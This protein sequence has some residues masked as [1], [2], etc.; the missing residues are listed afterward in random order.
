MNYKSMVKVWLISVVLIITSCAS[1]QSSWMTLEYSNKPFKN[2]ILESSN[3]YFPP[4]VKLTDG[5]YIWIEPVTKYQLSGAQS[6]GLGHDLL[7]VYLW[8]ENS[9]E[10]DL[11]SSSVKGRDG[12]SKSL[13]YVATLNE[14]LPIERFHNK[15]KLSASNPGSIRVLAGLTKKTA[16]PAKQPKG[17]DLKQANHFQLGFEPRIECSDEPFTISMRFIDYKGKE[18]ELPLYFYPVIYTGSR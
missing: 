15:A 8:S 18:F 6:C 13:K 17:R 7:N 10:L 12:V 3:Y 1:A 2:M 4:S 16:Q 11:G 5:I 14:S 9:I